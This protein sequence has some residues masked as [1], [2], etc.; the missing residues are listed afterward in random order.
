MNLFKLLERHKKLEINNKMIGLNWNP[1]H[2]TKKTKKNQ[3]H[4]VCKTKIITNFY[5]NEIKT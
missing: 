1:K 4:E 3:I 5:C 2:K